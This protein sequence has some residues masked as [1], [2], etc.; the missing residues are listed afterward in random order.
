M[1][2]LFSL[3]YFG[4]IA[5]YQ[6][7]LNCSK[8]RFEAFESWQ[9]QSYRNRMYIDGPNG[10]LML[11]IPIVHQGGKQVYKDV[12]ISY[13]DNWVNKHWQALKSSYNTSPFFEVLAPDIFKVMQEK[14][15]FLFDLNLKLNQLIWQWLELKIEK[16][17]SSEWNAK[18]E[19]ISD[20]R[21]IHHPKI[22]LLKNIE[23]YPQVFKHKAPF[24]SN[25]SIL[26]LIFNEGPATYDYLKNNG[27]EKSKVL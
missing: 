15:D 10:A 4:P 13:K 6:D 3:C 23:E 12:K 27:L 1:H 2:G 16:E 7:I 24:K 20:F 26:D 5:Y 9:K 22:P 18:P 21:N 17:I 19:F 25:L 14:P 11:N 8:I